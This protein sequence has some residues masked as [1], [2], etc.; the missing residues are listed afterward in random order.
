RPYFGDVIGYPEDLSS[1]RERAQ[2]I[3]DGQ[4]PY[5]DFRS[6]SPPLIMYLFVIPQALGGDIWIYQLYFSAFSV[7]TAC[8][9][10]CGLR[11]FDDRLAF[12]AGLL[13]FCLPFGI[14]EIPMGAQDEAITVLFFL[15]PLI[16]LLNNR[17][18]ASAF[19]VALGALS[20]LFNVLVFPWMLIGAG[21]G[22]DR[23]RLL[24]TV[25]MI[26]VAFV[27]PFLILAPEEFLNFPRY[28]LLGNPDYPT[29]G[30]SISPWHFL[31]QSGLDIPGWGG[32]AMTLGAVFG[33]TYLAYRWKLTLWEGSLFVMVAFFLFYPKIL[34]V[35]FLMPVALM[36]PW[37]LEDR[38]VMWR[39]LAMALPLFLVVSFSGN[40]MDPMTDA[41][42][43]W[44]VSLVL[45]LAGWSLFLQAWCLTRD[46]RCFIDR[47]RSKASKE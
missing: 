20:K 39:I 35:F 10:Y 46:R 33:S 9:L 8:V 2:A 3:L 24:L 43:G 41:S 32:V 31:K 21:T 45:S 42:W 37:A 19:G 40:G 34:F 29:G 23:T 12:L 16:L 18:T 17:V 5:R 6:E 30:S 25:I 13:Y 28:Y 26:G 36:I 15:L 38:R 44:V 22:K 4:I 1:Y 14:I 11:R 7:L 47:E 27:V